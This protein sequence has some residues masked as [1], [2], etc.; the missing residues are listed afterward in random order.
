MPWLVAAGITEAFVR[1]S[2]LPS[3]VLVAVGLGL[4]FTFWGLVWVRGREPGRRA[5]ADRGPGLSG[6]PAR[7]LETGP[8]LR[9]QI[10]ADAGGGQLARS[11]GR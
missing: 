2:G 1:S 3:A 4:F 9:A 11:G 6:P 5:G 7:G 8:S 10:G